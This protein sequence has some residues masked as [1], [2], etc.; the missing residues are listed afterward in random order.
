VKVLVNINSTLLW[1]V[2]NFFVLLWLLKKYLYGPLTEMLDK[3]AQ[4]IKGDLNEAAS[5]KEEA[6]KLKKEYKAELSKAREEGQEIIEKAEERSKQ[7]AD[8]II[9]EAKQEVEMIKERNLA[10]IEQAR[11]DA[12][13][14]LR[15]E[16]ASMALLAAGKFIQG[17]LDEKQ[18]KKLINQYI[19][20][21]DDEKLGE[22]H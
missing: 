20:E 9:V 15:N 6:E 8:E 18:H 14:Q 5:K 16:L 7:R 21:L 19:D 11:K 3:R 12:L 17:S 2:F 10:E 22:I 1:E 4:K 13:N